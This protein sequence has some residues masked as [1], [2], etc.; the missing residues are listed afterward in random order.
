MLIGCVFVFVTGEFVKTTI[1][2]KQ[3]EKYFNDYNW[4]KENTPENT[5]FYPFAHGLGY[6]FDR[7]I[8]EDVEV[9][10]YYFKYDLTYKEENIRMLD[11][12]LEKEM[13]LVYKSEYTD[14][15]VYKI[16]K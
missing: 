11:K 12:L 1:A 10:D 7:Y 4:V 5:V 9:I 6:S 15:E 16:I 2:T 3:H 8:S 13:E 14:V